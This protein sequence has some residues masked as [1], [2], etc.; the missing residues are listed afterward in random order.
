MSMPYGTPTPAPTTFGA[1][2]GGFV[3]RPGARLP[4]VGCACRAPPAGGLLGGHMLAFVLRRRARALMAPTCAARS[5]ESRPSTLTPDSGL[6]DGGL[7]AKPDMAPA[8]ASASS[9]SSASRGVAES[10]SGREPIPT[11]YPKNLASAVP[12]FSCSVGLPSLALSD[13]LHRVPRG[14]PTLPFLLYLSPE[15][16]RRGILF[17]TTCRTPTPDGPIWRR[18]LSRG[19][20]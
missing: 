3:T 1:D 8:T 18:T 16:S 19:T 2:M 4:C 13:T 14:S 11:G 10:K 5:L 9:A 15:G 17:V 20:R 12:P 6:R 7:P